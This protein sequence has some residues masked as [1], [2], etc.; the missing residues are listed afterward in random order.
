[1]S[2]AATTKLNA[3]KSAATAFIAIESATKIQPNPMSRLLLPSN[4]L[5]TN[6][7][8]LLLVTMDPQY[9]MPTPS[10]PTNLLLTNQMLL[11]LLQPNLIPLNSLKLQTN[12]I[13]V[14]FMF[15]WH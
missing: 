5:P 14:G 10:L 3:A 4:L 2:A 7:V 6:T 13:I 9:T 1:M 12:S 15:D 8:L 11:N